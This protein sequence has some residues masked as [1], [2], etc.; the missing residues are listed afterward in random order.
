MSVS[1]SALLF[2]NSS[3]LNLLAFYSV[4]TVMFDTFVVRI[5]LVP[6]LFGIKPEWNWWPGNVLKAKFL[7]KAVNVLGDDLMDD[8]QYIDEQYTDDDAF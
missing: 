6:A 4:G 3:A 7:K 1:F 8:E 2:S 5:F